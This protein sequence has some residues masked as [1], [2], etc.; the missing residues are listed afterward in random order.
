MG[1]RIGKNVAINLFEYLSAFSG[2]YE[3]WP[4]SS[5]KKLNLGAALKGQL[6]FS[7]L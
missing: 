1:L 3:K 5:R 7:L 4:N 2:G 6:Y